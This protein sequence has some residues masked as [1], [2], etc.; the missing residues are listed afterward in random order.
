MLKF[1]DEFNIESAGELK[2]YLKPDSSFHSV[3]NH[4]HG[5]EF[6]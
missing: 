5:K 6:K 1:E 3:L 2:M 4:A